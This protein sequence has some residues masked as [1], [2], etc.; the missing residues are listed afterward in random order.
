VG[1]AALLTAASLVVALGPGEP[2]RP[3]EWVGVGLALA[4]G[5]A[6]AVTGLRRER[7]AWPF[8]CALAVAA[9][10]VLLLVTR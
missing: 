8:R 2:L 7:S 10:D 5:L 9:V 6:A 1:S 3:V 4:L